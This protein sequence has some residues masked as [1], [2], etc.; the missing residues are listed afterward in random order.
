M[1]APGYRRDG[2]AGKREAVHAEGSHWYRREDFCRTRHPDGHSAANA[3]HLD[4]TAGCESFHLGA[5]L[6]VVCG[7]TLIS[8]TGS[9]PSTVNVAN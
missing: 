1:G 4:C 8:L 7:S 6:P 9:A 5:S 3:I 2:M